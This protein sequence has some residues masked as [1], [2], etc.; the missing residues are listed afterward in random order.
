MRPFSSR[1]G[2]A[3]LRSAYATDHAEFPVI[4]IGSVKSAGASTLALTIGSASA[5]NRLPVLMIDAGN[6]FDLS[7]WA[8][9]PG[10]PPHVEVARCD[11]TSQLAGLV[12]EGIRR[13]AV[14]IIDAGTRPEM[15]QAAQ[16]LAD[17]VMIP[18]RFSPL[19]AFAAAMTDRLLT[20]EREGAPGRRCFVATAI[21]QIPSRIAR[22][23]EAEV[24]RSTTERFPIGLAQRAAYEA[25]FMFGGTVFTLDEGIA[26]GLAR[27]QDEAIAMA[28]ELGVLHSAGSMLVSRISQTIRH[29]RR[30]AA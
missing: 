1:F 29:D 18:L 12:R 24:E 2:A 27:A 5:S 25:P 11:K 22:A 9:K 15:L 28:A 21:A 13:R 10:K 17:T 8:M 26:P 16:R 4:S 14:V 6:T 30:E 7:T 20:K 19:S 23:V 3:H